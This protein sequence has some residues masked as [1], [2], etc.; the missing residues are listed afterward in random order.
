MTRPNTEGGFK[1]SS[2]SVL[3]IDQLVC[4]LKGTSRAPELTEEGELV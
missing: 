2:P 4:A 3:G 1:G